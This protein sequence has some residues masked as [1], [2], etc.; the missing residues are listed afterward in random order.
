MKR[1][2]PKPLAFHILILQIS[3]QF[4]LLLHHPI[5]CPSMS[6][7]ICQLVTYQACK[8]YCF[9]IANDILTLIR[10][11]CHLHH[12]LHHQ[13]YFVPSCFQTWYLSII[14]SNPFHSCDQLLSKSP[15]SNLSLIIP[16][17]SV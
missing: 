6:P 16:I 14:F 10:H 17:T 5:F 2:S 12:V 8:L 7:H 3:S 1:R 9:I 11:E 4:L 13:F 15:V